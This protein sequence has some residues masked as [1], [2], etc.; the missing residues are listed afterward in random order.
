VIKINLLPQEKPKSF[1]VY[2]QIIGSSALLII[3]VVA[4]GVMSFLLS[5]EIDRKKQVQRQKEKTV[6]E[7]QVIID[8]V[9]QYEQDK[10]TLTSKLQTIETLQRNQRGPVLLL[11]EVSK[12]LP[13]Q[14]WM[15][16][17][18]NKKEKVT[19]RGF[20]LSLTSI[21]DFMTALENSPIFLGVKLTAAFLRVS[22]SREIYEFELLF[23][24]N[25]I[26]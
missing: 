18:Q 15:S 9:L 19:L 3:T 23:D 7:L 11:E 1:R 26:A 2:Y 8:Q 12:S 16:L 14:V 10:Q 17:L 4:V 5:S 20:A 22:G 6:Q 25:V 21:G 24:C 13:E